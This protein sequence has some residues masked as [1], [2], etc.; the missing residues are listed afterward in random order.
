MIL[1]EL[2]V[3]LNILYVETAPVWSVT[4]G[5]LLLYC[6]DALVPKRNN[7]NN[8]G[9]IKVPNKDHLTAEFSELLLR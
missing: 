7:P 6:H 1:Q 8:H 2:R 5:K 9:V 3:I 4:G